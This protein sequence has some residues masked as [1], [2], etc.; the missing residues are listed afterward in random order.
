MKKRIIGSYKRLKETNILANLFNLSGIQ[1]S[2]IVLLLLIIRIV[3]GVAGLEIL[4]LVMVANRFAQFIGAIVNY[5][6]NLSGVRDVAYHVNNPDKLGM[7]FYNILWIRS[8]IFSLF[9]LIFTGSYW[10]H[11]DSY[12]Y[13]LLAI[14]IVLAEVFNPLCFFIGTEKIKVY[15]VYNL[16]SNIVAIITILVFIKTPASAYWVN[17]ILGS[18]NTITYISLFVYL[19]TKYKIAFQLPVKPDL[20]KTARDNFYLT[21]NSVSGNLQQ[22][23]IVFALQWE[24]SALLGAYTL[25][26]RVIGQCRNLLNTIAN[27]I[28]PNAVHRYKQSDVLWSA[29]RKK[30]KYIL[31]GVFLAGGILIF[32]LADFIVYPILIDKPDANSVLLLRIMA[33][34]PFISALNVSNMLDQ[35]IKNN[36]VYMFK[37]STILFFI[38]ILL[39]FASISLNSYLLIGAFTLLIETSAWL[40]YEYIIKKPQIKNA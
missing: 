7:V 39:T 16:V 22:S 25:C 1:I 8:V 20:I 29:Y 5:G 30:T 27:A 36:T 10:L 21:V 40:M 32:I 6:T 33:F 18:L 35:L 31:A 12:S 15:N 28:Y 14:P 34:V 26:D 3:T 11:F 9:I 24:N 37:V 2:N 4:G 17:F 13:L 19:G 38:A 23:L